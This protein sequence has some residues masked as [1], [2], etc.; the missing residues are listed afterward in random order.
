MA[1]SRQIELAASAW[2]A[3]RDRGDWSAQ[4]QAQ[5][6]AWL[7]ESTAHRVAFLRLE[8][9]WRRSDRLKALGFTLVVATSA[10]SDELSRLLR[11]AQ[12]PELE[13]SATTS[14]DAENSKP[15]P[16]IVAAALKRAGCKA[17]E[18]VMLG[19][20]PYDVRAAKRAGVDAIALRCG[21]WDDA[22][23]AGAIA[24]YADPADL[25]AQLATSP[26]RQ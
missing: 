12:A 10:K 19:D 20:T 23:L 16:D 4:S 21:G 14:S 11:I 25:L 13:A 2:L 7:R 22:A 18:A 6:D 24:V 15:D 5:L 3:R 1:S 9:A 8:A 26:L 17:E